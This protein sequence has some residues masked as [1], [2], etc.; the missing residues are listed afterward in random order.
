M[1]EE[2]KDVY[3]W[4]VYC[5]EENKKVEYYGVEPPSVCPNDPNHQINPDSITK[6]EKVSPEISYIKDLTDS[7]GYFQTRSYEIEIPATN[8]V[9]NVIVKEFSF[10]FDMYI[11]EMSIQSD[12][13]NIGDML[14]VQFSP[15][16]FIG[17]LTEEAKSGDTS[18]TITAQ[19]VAHLYRGAEIG[20]RSPDE[21]LKEFP[22]M[23]VEFDEKTGVVEFENPINSDFAVGSN[24][25]FSRYP[26]RNY[27]FDSAQRYIIGSKG[28]GTTHI[29]LGTKIRVTYTDRTI[30][31]N[32][33]Y[34]RIHFQ[35]HMK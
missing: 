2:L 26:I 21:S 18:V 34:A 24:I 20:I 29:P 1:A 17:I 30:N 4:T 7:K 5:F 19:S 32:K 3:R 8:V 23:V 22:G 16:T 11:R 35:Y 10:P 25:L 27:V 33:T 15:D 31:D 14:D 12:I 6:L 13:S 28:V 9:P